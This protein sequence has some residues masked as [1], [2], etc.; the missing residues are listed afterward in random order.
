M[1]SKYPP[2]FKDLNK[3]TSDLLT[4]D[5]P[6]ERQ[7]NKIEWRGQPDN[8]VSLETSIT[9]KADGSASGLV[10]PKYSLREYGTTVSAEVTTRKDLKV[11]VAMEDYHVKGLKTTLGGNL[12]PDDKWGT[13]GLE[14]RHEIG[15][16]T[17]N[18]DYGKA[19]GS[20][21]KASAV[22]GSQGIHLGGSA[23]YLLG[24]DSSDVKELKT[25]LSYTADNFE[26][27]AYGLMKA[28]EG[29]VEEKNQIGT[30]F[31]HRFTPDWQIAAEA[32]FDTAPAD[33]KPTLFVASQ[34][35]LSALLESYV[36]AKFDTNG[37]LGLSYI[38]RYNKNA[39]FGVST[40]V[41]TNKLDTKGAATFGF[42]LSLSD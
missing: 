9:T 20:T 26:I 16:L 3:K 23:V 30:N 18:F 12:T 8:N 31:S 15:N 14:Y 35:R 22:V 41:D 36:K 28:A 19:V 17:G 33:S 27:S 13:F 38:Q 34:Y 11:E 10:A 37:R 42:T 4:K 25:T 39:K 24:N 32:I 6:S 1:Y 5:F 7:E 40:T 29:K 2:L 21:V